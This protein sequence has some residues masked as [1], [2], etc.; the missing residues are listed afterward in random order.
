[1]QTPEQDKDSLFDCR[2]SIVCLLREFAFSW[3]YLELPSNRVNSI[4][5]EHFRFFPSSLLSCFSYLKQIH[6]HQEKQSR[7][8]NSVTEM[9]V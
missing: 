6:F 9:T 4:C 8:L 5:D 1:M 3:I 2:L 7:R